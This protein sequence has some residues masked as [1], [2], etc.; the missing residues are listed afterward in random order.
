MF[1]QHDDIYW[2]AIV[3]PVWLSTTSFSYCQQ[4][5]WNFST[6][7]KKLLYVYATCVYAL[8]A[9][10]SHVSGAV[11]TVRRPQDGR[12]VVRVRRSPPLFPSEVWNVYE[13][14][15]AACRHRASER[16]N[17]VCELRLVEQRVRRSS[18]HLHGR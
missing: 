8:M 6:G 1:N 17:N 3:R 12:N 5:R 16:A 2:R 9:S 10:K 7:G 15:L 18:V 14:T 13:A 4:S 11:R